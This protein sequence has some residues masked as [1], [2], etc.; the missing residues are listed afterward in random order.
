MRGVEKG[1][2]FSQSQELASSRGGTWAQ[3]PLTSKPQLLTT[4]I[5]R[6]E[7]KKEKKTDVGEYHHVKSFL[8]Y[9]L[10]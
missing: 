3:I 6:S 9:S 4:T 7:M 8:N 2:S 1:K 10:Y 5:L